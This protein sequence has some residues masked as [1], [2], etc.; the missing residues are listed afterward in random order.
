MTLVS[1]PLLVFGPRRADALTARADAL[2]SLKQ[3]VDPK[4]KHRASLKSTELVVVASPGGRSAWA[5]DL[6]SFDG[7]PLAATAVLS[8][9]GDIWLVS[10]VAIA[11]T[12]SS[13]AVTTELDK[14][15]VVPPALAAATRVDPAARAA[16]DKLT[17]GLAAQEVWGDDLSTRTDAVFIGP[18]SGDVARGKSDIKKLWKK[19]LKANTRE[20][21][22][23]EPA[24]QVTPDGQLAWVTVPVVRFADKQP[25][26]PLRVF[27]IFEKDAADWHLIALQESLAVDA[28]GSGS[29]LA[30]TPPPP[31]PKA[32]EPPK[33]PPSTA[34]TKT[35][36][37]TKPKKKKHHTSS[38]D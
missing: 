30:K 33:P 15:A 24:A 11:E 21:A 31:L 27:A 34:K 20:V 16:A 5:F 2:V 32:E 19:R 14:Q 36:T 26:T 29:A 38:S 6:V 13:H 23:G 8:N 17:R 12:P 35:K 28:P 25:P 22:V 18:T 4:A 37:K 1:D 3:L 9:A 10:A 7:R